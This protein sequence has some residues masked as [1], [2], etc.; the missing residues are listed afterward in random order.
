MSA[1]GLLI[2]ACHQTEQTEL[3]ETTKLGLGIK[4]RRVRSSKPT[5]NL[6]L[7]EM[8]SQGAGAPGVPD[9]SSNEME[10]TRLYSVVT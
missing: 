9:K 8:R 4:T 3:R 1:P 6:R 10:T 5:L 2:E 7:R